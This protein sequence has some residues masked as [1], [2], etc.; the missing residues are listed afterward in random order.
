MS[1]FMFIRRP[2]RRTIADIW[3]FSMPM[4]APAVEPMRDEVVVAMSA[5]A[6]SREFE[7]RL[8]VIRQLL[9]V[10]FDPGLGPVPL[11]SSA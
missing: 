6:P 8:E 9:R 11:G 7:R 5:A 10:A 4:T 3:M 2:R 1:S